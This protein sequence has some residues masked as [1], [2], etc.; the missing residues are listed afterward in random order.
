MS[1]DGGPPDGIRGRGKP[2]GTAGGGAGAGCVGAELEICARDRGGR[3]VGE[4]DEE[5]TIDGVELS[6]AFPHFLLLLPHTPHF[7]LRSATLSWSALVPPPHLLL[8]PS[9]LLLRIP[10][11]P[12]PPRSLPLQLDTFAPSARLPPPVTRSVKAKLGGSSALIRR[13]RFWRLTM[14]TIRAGRAR[15]RSRIGRSLRLLAQ[16]MVMKRKTAGTM[17]TMTTE[18]RT[19]TS[20]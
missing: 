15:M 11:R 20:K 18:E 16:R 13:R 5:R 10:P 17:S 9:P 3:G 8:P 6:C 7:N 1:Q 14:R 12:L 19:K 4:E 2:D